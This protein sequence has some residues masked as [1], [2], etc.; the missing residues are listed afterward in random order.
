MGDVNPDELL[1]RL[2]DIRERAESELDRT[3]LPSQEKRLRQIL[4]HGRLL[5][6]PL[7]KVLTSE[8]VAD[9]L[10]LSAD[11]KDMLKE[12]WQQIEQKLNS[13]IAKLRAR[14]RKELASKLP[15]EQRQKYAQLFGKDFQFKANANDDGARKER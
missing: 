7:I 5:R 12:E 1:D 6:E 2:S 4:M 14:A 10:G 3:L 8:P 11:Q 13:D 15:T 9:E